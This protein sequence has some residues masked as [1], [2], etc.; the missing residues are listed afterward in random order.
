M[1]VLV[2]LFLVLGFPRSSALEF[3]IFLSCCLDKLRMMTE[4]SP[5]QSTLECGMCWKHNCIVLI[6]LNF[7]I[8]TILPWLINPWINCCVLTSSWEGMG[9]GRFRRKKICRS[10]HSLSDVLYLPHT[11]YCHI[12]P[13]WW[14]R[15]FWD[16][17]RLCLEW[18]YKLSEKPQADYE[19]QRLLSA[20]ICG[21]I[22]FPYTTWAVLALN[23]Y[24]NKFSHSLIFKYLFKK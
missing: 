16:S 4:C 9:H 21:N 20:S 3:L 22:V 18:V 24:T 23:F 11:T 5:C 7:L 8:V 15:V 10:A 17:L 2:L 6:Y 12:S 19:T 13:C 1:W 14:A